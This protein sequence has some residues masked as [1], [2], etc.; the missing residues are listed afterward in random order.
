MNAHGLV[1]NFLSRLPHGI[2]CPA[3]IVEEDGDLGFDWDTGHRTVISASLREDGRVAWAA[4]MGDWKG[5]GHF[6]LPAWSDE[7]T[8]ALTKY[9]TAL[10]QGDIA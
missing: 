2:G 8:E 7:F 10:Q 1:R 4:M 3:V 6:T 5:H 9:V